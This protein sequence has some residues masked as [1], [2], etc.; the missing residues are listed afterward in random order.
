MKQVY[1]GTNWKMHKTIRESEEYA[2]LLKETC[3][4]IPDRFTIFIIPALLSLPRVSEI[5]SGTKI[6]VGSQ[7]MHWEPQGAYTGEVSPLMLRE[8]GI[9]IV[10]IGHSE[11]RQFFGETDYTVNKKVLS[12]LQH[13]LTPL[14]CIGEPAT[15]KTYGVEKQYVLR[16][17]LIALKGVSPEDLSKIMLAYEPV[18]S[19]GESGVP[20]EPSYAESMHTGI[21]KALSDQYG[22]ERAETVPILYGGSVNSTNAGPFLLRQNI[23][24]LFIGRSA[25]EVQGF[26][27][28]I[29]NME[30]ILEQKFQ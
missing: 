21:R 26:L 1:L 22:K 25:W 10:E 30:K 8:I 15:E 7:N 17:M 29:R 2:N 18:W 19:I 20:A 3:D 11:R 9:Q 23:D 28:I 27:S 12:A 4:T 14:V 6:K 24:G 16:Q 5:L 13:G